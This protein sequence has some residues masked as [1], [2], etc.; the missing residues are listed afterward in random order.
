LKF[1][2]EEEMASWKQYFDKM[3]EEYTIVMKKKQALSSL[4]SSG[5]ISQSTFELFDKEMDETI[6]DI[7]RQKSLLLDKMNGKITELE[8]HIKTLEKLL[9]NFEIQHVGGEIDEEVYQREIALL[10]IGLETAKQ[11]L[12]SIKDAVNKLTSI[13]KISENVVV[14]EE[15]ETKPSE[16]AETSKVEVSDIEVETETP[17][18]ESPEQIT[19]ET[20]LEPPTET[21]ETKAEEETGES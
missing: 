16:T 7:E 6:A 18:V 8:E 11:E 2:G 20:V 13:P 3:N 17:E 5:K 14:Q 1:V 19:Q 10:S 21:A 9:A 12:E 15:V 4:V